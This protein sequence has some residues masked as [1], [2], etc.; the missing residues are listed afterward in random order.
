[1][2]QSRCTAAKRAAG[3]PSF[4]PAAAQIEQLTPAARTKSSRF[5]VRA[6]TCTRETLFEQM[7]RRYR[8]GLLLE[9]SMVERGPAL[10]AA[11]RAELCL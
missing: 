5:N 10:H 3:P 11:S 7:Y 4:R 2:N 1:M 6:V 9:D 8:V